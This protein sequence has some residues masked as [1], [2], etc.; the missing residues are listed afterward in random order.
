MRGKLIR[1]APLA[2]G[3]VL[4]STVSIGK[5]FRTDV[6]ERTRTI[7]T[8]STTKSASGPASPQGGAP[9]GGSGPAA[10]LP[11]SKP[12][13][14]CARGRNGG[15][16]DTGV[17]GTSIKLGATVVKSGIGASFLKEVPIALEAVKNKVNRRG[18]VCGRLLELTMV[19][20]GWKAARGQQFIRSFIAQGMFALA[21]SPS[22]EGLDAAI[23]SGDIR[24]AGIP[25]VGADG[26]LVSQ[27]TDPWVWPVAASTMTAM[28]VMAKEAAQ[29]V[30]PGQKAA[31]TFGLVYD[32]TYHFGVEGAAA[33]RGAL[34]RL[35]GPQ[36]VLRADVGIE[37]DKGS[38]KVDV[39]EFN[40]GCNRCDFVAMLLE[41]ATALQWIRDGASFGSVK[42]GGPQP[43][44]V[45]SFARS[46]GTPCNGMWVWSG[47]R[48]PVW[49]FDDDPGVV[50]YKNDVEAQRS[51]I[52]TSNPFVQ[53]G[54][55]GMQ[56][57]VKGLEVVGPELTRKRLQTAL[58]SLVLDIGLSVP[59]RWTRGNHYA[60]NSAQAFSIVINTGA[61]SGWRYEQTGWVADPWVGLDVPKR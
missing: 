51:T 16:T 54:Y 36:S 50:R 40:R 29:P 1:L 19:D 6:Q 38:Y 8:G 18:G 25:V 49:P 61:F 44:F 53:G 30:I 58:D 57:L 12:G 60:N 34:R 20:D 2:A 48:P 7:A 52:D 15:S 10:P 31:K 22:S 24:R 5:Q 45:D 56:L 26:M 41:P 14:E 35:F 37:A 39:D 27:Y 42:T 9:V 17:T 33:F 3:I 23:R 47:Y 13:L 28:H 4:V 46:C 21:V 55:L 43:L 59:L 32:K 11:A